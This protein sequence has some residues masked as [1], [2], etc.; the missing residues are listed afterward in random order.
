[1]TDDILLSIETFGRPRITASTDRLLVTLDS[2]VGVQVLYALDGTGNSERLAGVVIYTRSNED[3]I[4]VL[5]IAVNEQYTVTGLFSDRL[6]V[7]RVI[8][9]LRRIASYIRGIRWLRLF[10]RGGV[11]K[12]P[13]RG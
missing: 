5:H 7:I 10:Y 8:N 11:V 2:P 4:S 12:I 6:L 9:E 1:M 3:S 13:V